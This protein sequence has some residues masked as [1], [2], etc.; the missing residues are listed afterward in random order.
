MPILYE[1]Y[2]VSPEKGLTAQKI[3]TRTAIYL[4]DVADGKIVYTSVEGT[5]QFVGKQIAIVAT[6]HAKV[7][8]HAHYPDMCYSKIHIYHKLNTGPWELMRTVEICRTSEA[9]AP[10]HGGAD[11]FYT[12]TKAGTHTFYA[13]YDGTDKYA[14]SSKAAKTFAR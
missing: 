7:D 4:W 9:G 8:G 6:M 12:L 3:P 10:S 14:G 1:S 13:K 2:S 5:T 11:I